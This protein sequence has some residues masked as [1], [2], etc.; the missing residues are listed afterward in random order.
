MGDAEVMASAEFQRQVE[1]H[2]AMLAAYRAQ[3]WDEAAARVAEIRAADARLEAFCDLYDERIRQYRLEPP[4]PDWD[5][6]F[7]ATTK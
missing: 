1:L 3:G 4:G 2:T 5:G 7:V 6:V